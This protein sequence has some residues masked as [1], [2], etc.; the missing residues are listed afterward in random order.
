MSCNPATKDLGSSAPSP[1][2][3]IGFV[4]EVNGPGSVEFNQ[5]HPSQF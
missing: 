3:V 4:D 1:G 5:Y 2:A